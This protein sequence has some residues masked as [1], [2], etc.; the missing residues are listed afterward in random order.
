MSF[1]S[2]QHSSRLVEAALDRPSGGGSGYVL[3][4]HGKAQVFCSTYKLHKAFTSLVDLLPSPCI[5]FIPCSATPSINHMA[6]IDTGNSSLSSAT[7]ES[8]LAEALFLYRSNLKSDAAGSVGLT[9]TG[10][11]SSL[12]IL[13]V[14]PLTSEVDGNGV[15]T[16]SLLDETDDGFSFTPDPV[17]DVQAATLPRSEERRGRE[18]V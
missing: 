1:Y 13:A 7:Y 9:F 15:L 5:W 16:T 17:S 10:N 6:I 11:A 3:N 12:R 8:A 2:C 14:L 18:R 4:P